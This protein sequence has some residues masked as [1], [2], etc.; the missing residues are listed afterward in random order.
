MD[1][2]ECIKI[3]CYPLALERLIDL[4]IQ[5]DRDDSKRVDI[6][7]VVGF[8]SNSVDKLTR[9]SHKPGSLI[10]AK[11]FQSQQLDGELKFLNSKFPAMTRKSLERHDELMHSKL[12]IVDIKV[13]FEG[14]VSTV[15]FENKCEKASK[16]IESNLPPQIQISSTCTNS[17]TPLSQETIINLWTKLLSRLF[18]HDQTQPS[19][20]SNTSDSTLFEPI[21]HLPAPSSTFTA[22]AFS[23]KKC[24][25][26]HTKIE[27]DTTDLTQIRRLGRD[28][29]MEL[30]QRVI[31]AGKSE[32]EGGG[33]KRKRSGALKP[34]VFN[35]MPEFFGRRVGGG[36][37]ARILKISDSGLDSQKKLQKI[38]SPTLV[39]NLN[40]PSTTSTTSNPE[41]LQTPQTVQYTTSIT[42]DTENKENILTWP[43]IEKLLESY[44]K[45]S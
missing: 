12:V 14:L 41:T 18:D 5:I 24:T 30:V 20:H 39:L 21:S 32:V 35:S 44:R 23:D 4:L 1:A 2:N 31:R 17:P 26:K 38:G 7:I 9:E 25:P 34:P 27:P 11:R 36:G 13:V 22:I 10:R 28:E 40:K 15:G 6:N 42:V 37:I 16:S 45:K 3:A 29:F 8:S 43:E 33:E 19:L